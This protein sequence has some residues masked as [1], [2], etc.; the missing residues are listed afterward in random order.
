MNKK[1]KIPNKRVEMNPWEKLKPPMKPGDIEEIGFQRASR[2]AKKIP[3]K[4]KV[5]TAR[6]RERTR[7]T[8]LA[9][10]FL[11]N[12][13]RAIKILDAYFEAPEFY[14]DLIKLYFDENELKRIHKRLINLEKAVEEIAREYIDKINSE[15]DTEEMK[16]WRRVAQGKISTFIHRVAEDLNY[17]LQ[18][19]KYARKLPSIDPDK[20]TFI[21]AGP[22]NT[23]K[24]TLV[25]RLSSAKTKVASY[26]FTTKDIHVGHIEVGF[27][28][29]QLIDTP[30]LLDREMSER[31][32]VELKAI[33]ALKHLKGPIIYLY[34][35]SSS[36]YYPVERQYRIHK[37]IQEMFRDKSVYPVANKIDIA[38]EEALDTLT[39]LVGGDMPRISLEKGIGLD[40]LRNW[41]TQYIENF[42]REMLRR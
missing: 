38:D 12:I 13:R 23:G 36:A 30:G 22:P 25:N 35:I 37:E 8:M 20:P 7:V 2:E 31:N 14:R 11:V 39:K 6:K 18:L 34:D 33:T 27:M 10:T 1:E 21:V 15:E 3:Y 17:V 28:K 26:P 4:G 32:E 42:Y 5:E 40:R 41:I 29:G 16:K 19:Y 9:R 24:S